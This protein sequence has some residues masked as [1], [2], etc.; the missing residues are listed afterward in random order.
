MWLDELK[1]SYPTNNSRNYSI[2]NEVLFYKYR[3]YTSRLSNLGKFEWVH[4]SPLHMAKAEFYWSG[5]RE[6]IKKFI[7]EC[8]MR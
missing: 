4:S 2:K 7:Q 1:T 5:M 3:I 6:E 8:D